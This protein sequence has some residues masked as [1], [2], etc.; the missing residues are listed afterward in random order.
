M[1]SGYIYVRTV[2]FLWR[3]SELIQLFFKHCVMYRNAPLPVLQRC[4]RSTCSCGKSLENQRLP[5]RSC[6]PS[7]KLPMGPNRR[8]KEKCWTCDL[9]NCNHKYLLFASEQTLALLVTQTS[10]LCRRGQC[11]AEQSQSLLKIFSFQ[12]ELE[13]AQY[14]LLTTLAAP[15]LNQEVQTQRGKTKKKGKREDKIQISL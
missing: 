13:M 9:A 1:L 2:T 11:L 15:C 3:T 4:T 6:S 5:A 8:K 12:F 7:A 14:P 10:D